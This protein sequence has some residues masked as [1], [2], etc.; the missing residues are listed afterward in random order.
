M[1]ASRGPRVSQGVASPQLR[2]A[3]R[4][5]A[6]RVTEPGALLRARTPRACAAARLLRPP[7]TRRDRRLLVARAPADRRVRWA[8]QI[9]RRLRRVRRAGALAREEARRS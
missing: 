9:R 7:R 2:L 8:R 6:G 5:V 3:S 4:G 1:D